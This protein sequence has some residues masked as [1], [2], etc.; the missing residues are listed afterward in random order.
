[1]KEEMIGAY[2]LEGIKTQELRCLVRERERLINKKN[3]KRVRLYVLGQD[4]RHGSKKERRRV[5][6]L[7]AVERQLRKL[8][9]TSIF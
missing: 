3:K 8:Q 1:M 7:F 4:K 9:G 2:L 5:E 6:M